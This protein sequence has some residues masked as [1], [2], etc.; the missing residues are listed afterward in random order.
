MGS[1]S[2]VLVFSETIQEQCNEIK[3]NACELVVK[4]HTDCSILMETTGNLDDI[5]FKQ[6][7]KRSKSRREALKIS[8][9][10]NEQGKK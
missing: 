2:R 3:L 9:I 6:D 10:I 8:S 1:N 4:E 5:D 7:C